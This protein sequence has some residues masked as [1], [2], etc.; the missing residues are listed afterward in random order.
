MVFMGRGWVRQGRGGYV[1]CKKG[2]SLMTTILRDEFRGFL[3]V[4]C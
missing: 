1:L 2:W 3:Y 4:E